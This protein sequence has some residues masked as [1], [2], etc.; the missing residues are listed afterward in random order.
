[1]QEH[2]EHSISI[3]QRAKLTVTG[4]ES[5]SSFSEVKILLSLLNG[6]KL[7]VIGIGL[8]ISG[9]SKTNGTFMAEGEVTG[10]TY[11]GKS[12]VAKLLK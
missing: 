4:V 10:L 1:M 8:K 9:F 11:N 7:Q 2:I 12:F 6:E 3:E 5:V